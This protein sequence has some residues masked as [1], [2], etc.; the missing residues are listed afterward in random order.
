MMLRF[1]NVRREQPS[2]E[3]FSVKEAL[4]SLTV[5]ELK[6]RFNNVTERQ[7]INELDTL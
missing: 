2:P 4:N 5:Y 6:E 7:K 3:T 1:V